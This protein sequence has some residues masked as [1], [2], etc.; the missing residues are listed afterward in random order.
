M[1][2][3]P[4]VIEAGAGRPVVLLH[5]FPLNASMWAPQREQLS[6]SWR[7][8]C[9]DQRGFGGSP[10]PH[11]SRPSVDTLADD[12]A[13]VL[14]AK[15]IDQPIVLGGLSMGGYV[16]MAFWRRHRE[17][18]AALVLADT[19]ASA[20]SPEAAVNRE[21]I[22][23]EVVTARSSAILVTEMLSQLVGPTTRAQR[24]LVHGR[25]K[26]LIE[27]APPHAV[28]WAQRAMAARPDSLDDLRTVDVPA[29]V[30]VGD[31][32]EISPVSDAEE[33]ARALPNSSLVTLAAAGHLAAMETPDDFN[34]ALKEF[35]AGLPE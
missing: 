1:R 34:A 12:L 13:A 9:P 33:M 35:L 7:V 15:R 2:A 3:D 18:V 16:A 26:A 5:A 4:Y 20:D 21:R 10:L 22:A 25:V 32:D 14:D 8:L 29:L 19:K 30:I 11:D 6:S 28:A 17:R 24:P 27:S 31:E 23:T